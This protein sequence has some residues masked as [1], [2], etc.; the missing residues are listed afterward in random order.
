MLRSAVGIRQA[1]ECIWAVFMCFVWTNGDRT[2]VVGLLWRDLLNR[3][4][5]FIDQRGRGAST[6]HGNGRFLAAD[7]DKESNQRF[8]EKLDTTRSNKEKSA[9]ILCF[10]H[11]IGVQYVIQTGHFLFRGAGRIELSRGTGKRERCW[12]PRCLCGSTPLNA[13]AP[14]GPLRLDFGHTHHD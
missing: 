1:I 9:P 13:H 10:S 2:L 14:A 7:R 6:S 11:A 4:H 5:G 12:P 8:D 3:F